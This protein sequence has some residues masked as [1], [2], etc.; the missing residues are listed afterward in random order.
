MNGLR[1]LI[2]FQKRSKMKDLWRIWAKA[3]GEKAGTTNEEAD[4][5][6]I[7]RTIIILIYLGTNICIVAGI[8]RHW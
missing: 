2:G 7:I 8:I 4:R 1:K 5:I 6:A 3:L